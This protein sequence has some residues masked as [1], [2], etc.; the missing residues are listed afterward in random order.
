MIRIFFLCFCLLIMNQVVRCQMYAVLPSGQDGEVIYNE[1][2][3]AENGIVSINVEHLVKRRGQGMISESE[4]TEYSFNSQGRL[5]AM[6]T[7]DSAQGK[8]NLEERYFSGEGL[9]ETLE[10][11]TGDRCMMT[12]FDYDSDGRMILEYAERYTCD[13][14]LDHEPIRFQTRA[15][16]YST[17]NDST[18]VRNHLNNQ[19]IPYLKETLKFDS[20]GVYL[21][22][23]QLRY[24]V[25]GRKEKTHY[26]YNEKG[27]LAEVEFGGLKSVFT[28][29][30]WGELEL[31]TE[32]R[33]GGEYSVEEYLYDSSGLIQ[34]RLKKY[35]DSPS[36]YI[37]KYSIIL[38]SDGEE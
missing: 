13:T 22:E 4:E 34:A 6:A 24:V 29:S 14:V 30:K 27:W 9:L 5:V 32:Y 15:F 26:H 19:N 1:G 7:I 23:R 25:S 8:S 28:Y 37:K 10:S 16:S 11:R 35:S 17:P 33:N 21:K 3:V 12:V 20:S 31:V 18:L 36:V 38:N 2:F